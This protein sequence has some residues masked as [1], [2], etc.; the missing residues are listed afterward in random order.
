MID[1]I[2]IIADI[3][4][5]A[6]ILKKAISC[7]WKHKGEIIAKLT[8][9]IN[10]KVEILLKK[11]KTHI[12]ENVPQKRESETRLKEFFSREQQAISSERGLFGGGI[13]SPLLPFEKGVLLYLLERGDYFKDDIQKSY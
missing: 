11:R 5:I 8:N 7:L 13:V 6:G 4:T 2:S 1:S 3:I 9:T 10:E 12:I